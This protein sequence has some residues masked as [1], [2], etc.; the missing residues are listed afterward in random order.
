MPAV[1]VENPLTLPRVHA[2]E[3]A[4]PRPV[5]AVS[6]APGGFEGE[7]FPVRRAFAGI[8]YQ[9][10]DPFIMMDQMGEVEYAPGEPKGTPWHPH[11]GFETVTYLIDGTFV[12]QDSNGGGGTINDGDTQW[13]TAGSGLLHIEAPPES[14]VVS[15]GLFHGLQLWVNLPA[16][17]KMM[18]PRY[19]DIGGGQVQLLTSPDGGALLRVI[20]GELDGHDG[21]GITHTPITMIHATVRPGAEVTLP[22]REDFNGLAYVLAGRGS[23]GTDRRPAHTGQTAVFGA[24]SSLTVRADETQEA[25][26]PDLEVVLLGGRPIRE[27][28]AHYGPF[29]MNSEAELKQAFEDFQ[30]G[31]LGTVPAVHGM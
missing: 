1:T 30:R 5:L 16:S 10:L 21:P 9:Y 27:P 29:V 22:W 12:H 13:M 6:T 7:G 3:G 4:V 15:G 18:A 8:N 11:R 26:S 28:M 2:P 17:D 19:Q 14:L 24:G 20:A 25:K 31:R 23:V